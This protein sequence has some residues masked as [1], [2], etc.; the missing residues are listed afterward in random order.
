MVSLLVEQRCGKEHSP[1]DLTE[2]CQIVLRSTRDPVL[3]TAEAVE[4]TLSCKWIPS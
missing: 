1:L 2:T 3:G 4:E